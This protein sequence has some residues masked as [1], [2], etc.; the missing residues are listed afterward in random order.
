MTSAMELALRRIKIACALNV[1]RD[2]H[3]PS[4]IAHRWQTMPC[5]GRNPASASA[6]AVPTTSVSAAK[7]PFLVD[8]V[9]RHLHEHIRLQL[10]NDETCGSG[11]HE[12]PCSWPTARALPPRTR[13]FSREF[14]RVSHR[15]RASEPHLRLG[16]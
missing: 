10:C 1:V 14:R 11:S 12:P 15:E 5:S 13:L 2:Q 6:S 3:R 7:S 9:H 4:I 8:L 16:N